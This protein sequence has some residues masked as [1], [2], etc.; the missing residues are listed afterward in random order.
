MKSIRLERGGE[1]EFGAE[2][3]NNTFAGGFCVCRG[4]NAEGPM[5]NITDGDT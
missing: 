4:G 2:K 5:E 3:E 1:A